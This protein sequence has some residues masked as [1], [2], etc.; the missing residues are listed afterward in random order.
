MRAAW[1][2][3]MKICLTIVPVGTYSWHYRGHGIYATA[4]VRR[5][6]VGADAQYVGSMTLAPWVMAARRH[7][8]NDRSRASRY[9]DRAQHLGDADFYPVPIAR[10]ISKDYA[11]QRFADFDPARAS[12][13]A[14]I[15]A[16]NIPYESPETTHA[17]V[18]DAEGN[19]VAYTTTLNLSYGAKMV[20]TGAGFLLN[21]EM[22]D[23][24]ERRQS[25]R[26][27]SIDT[28]NAIEPGK[29]MPAL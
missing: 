24:S 17:S 27:W 5:Y 1:S 25:Q 2:I 4:F 19:A 14:D 21:N 12:I 22:D 7:S 3:S 18:M 16:G 23:F 11:Q 9:A 13:S 26:F 8:F 6:F 20:V 15:G 10:L 28:A 29:R